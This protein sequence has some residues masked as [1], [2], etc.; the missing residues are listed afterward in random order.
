MSKL[1]GRRVKIVGSIL[2]KHWP[3]SGIFLG[4]TGYI[5]GVLTLDYVGP[6][7]AVCIDSQSWGGLVGDHIVDFFPEELRY[8]NNKKVVL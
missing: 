5:K 1:T 7:I 8:L 4:S 6:S 2:P 3:L